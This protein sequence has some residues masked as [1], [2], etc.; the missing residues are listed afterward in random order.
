MVLSIAMVFIILEVTAP[1]LSISEWIKENVINTEKIGKDFMTH[2]PVL[3]QSI[4]YVVVI[5]IE[6]YR[7]IAPEITVD[8]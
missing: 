4:I 8:F 5:S 6:Y 3:I 1:G 2:L 7:I